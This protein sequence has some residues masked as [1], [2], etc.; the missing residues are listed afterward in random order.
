MTKPKVLYLRDVP[1]DVLN[2]LRAA[3]ALSGGKSVQK[4]VIQLLLEHVAELERK[5][6]L[7][8]GRHS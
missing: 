2:K 7:P 5:G 3:A 6:Q 8:K 4:Y 1:A